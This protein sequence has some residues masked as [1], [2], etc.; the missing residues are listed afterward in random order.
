MCLT[1]DKGSVENSEVNYISLENIGHGQC[2]GV[3]K[4]SMV[5]IGQGQCGEQ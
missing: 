3:D 5:N 2:V 1:L 4:G